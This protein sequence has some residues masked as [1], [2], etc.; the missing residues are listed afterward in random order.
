MAVPTEV[1]NEDVKELRLDI[2]EV[3]NKI[4]LVK[5]ESQRISLG[6]ADLKGEFRLIKLLLVLVIGGIGGTSLQYVRLESRVGALETKADKLDA[7]MERIETQLSALQVS[8][9]KLLDQAKPLH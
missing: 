6:L 1:L 2:R 3:R 4:D 8:I 7:R 5:D 9:A